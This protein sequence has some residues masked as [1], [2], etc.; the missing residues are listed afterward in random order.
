MILLVVVSYFHCVFFHGIKLFKIIED[1]LDLGVVE[2]ASFCFGMLHV[3]I[4]KKNVGKNFKKLRFYVILFIYKFNQL[5]FIY[6]FYIVPNWSQV[7]PSLHI[8][9]SLEWCYL[10]RNKLHASDTKH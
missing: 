3:V 7:N 6:Y 9:F 8:V 10:I 4:W 5:S 1:A 2:D